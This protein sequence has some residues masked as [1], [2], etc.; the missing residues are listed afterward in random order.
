MFFILLCRFIF[1]NSNI[2]FYLKDLLNISYN[3]GVLVTES[4]SF[5]VSENVIILL[6]LL[7]DI[8]ARYRILSWQFFFF[9][10]IRSVAPIWVYIVFSFVLFLMWNLLS[11]IFVPL[12]DFCIIPTLSNFIMMYLRVFNLVFLVLRIHE[13]SWTCGFM[14]F[15]QFGKLS[16]IMSSNIFL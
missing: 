7:E 2:S 1:L 12:Y 6:L 15:M 3:V 16:T 4:Y 8:F 13:A 11:P 5:C 9:Q 14:G 10:Y